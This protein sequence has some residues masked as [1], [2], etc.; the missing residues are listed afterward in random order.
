MLDGADSDLARC[1]RIADPRT[2]KH[3]TIL[4]R[5]KSPSRKEVD[6]KRETMS[7]KNLTYNYLRRHKIAS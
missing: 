3:N 7:V 5:S 2:P 6:Y 4:M 1:Y